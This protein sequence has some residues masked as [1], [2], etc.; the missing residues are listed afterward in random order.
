VP[1]AN[2][3]SVRGA[4][5]NLFGPR[6]DDLE[7]W[8]TMSRELQ[9]EEAVDLDELL[10]TLGPDSMANKSAGSKLWLDIALLRVGV[11]K[12]TSRCRLRINRPDQRDVDILT[13]VERGWLLSNWPTNTP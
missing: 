2:I 10:N 6:L 12:S 3:E 5:F 4:K 8:Q 1:T 7:G 9:P 11:Q 13:L